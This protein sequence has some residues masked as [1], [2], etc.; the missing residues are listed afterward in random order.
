MIY[1]LFVPKSF[2]RRPISKIIIIIFAISFIRREHKHA[3]KHTRERARPRQVH[4]W[5]CGYVA[6]KHTSAVRRLSFFLMKFT[7]FSSEGQPR[8]KIFHSEILMNANV[9]SFE[10]WMAWLRLQIAHENIASS[11]WSGSAVQ[12][13][14]FVLIEWLARACFPSVPYKSIKLARSIWQHLTDA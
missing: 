12:L 2:I 10:A 9:M 8:K 3:N 14:K 1:E 7:Y 13:F 5:W 4:S 11:E 6:R